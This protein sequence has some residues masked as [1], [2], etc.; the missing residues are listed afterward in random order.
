MREEL[1]RVEDHPSLV[2][3][4][5]SKALLNTDLAAL[6][7]YKNKQ[8]L[9]NQ[10]KDLTEEVAGIKQLLTQILDRLDR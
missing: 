8:K 10:V 2:R 1:I 9:S 4:K 3:N 5:H 7:E 6:Q